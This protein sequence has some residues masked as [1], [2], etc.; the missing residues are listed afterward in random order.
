MSNIRSYFLYTAA[1]FILMFSLSFIKPQNSQAQMSQNAYLQK[2][3]AIMTE[4]SQV[5]DKVSKTAIGLQ[6]A[7]QDKCVNEFGFYQEIVGSLISRLSSTAPPTKMKPLHIKS[8]EALNDYSTGLNL[9]ASACVDE[10]YAM[11][12]KLVNSA[13]GY[14]TKADQQVAEVNTLIASPSLI[15]EYATTVDYIAE[16]CGARWANNTDMQNYCIRTQTEARA[17]LANMLQMNPKGTPGSAVIGDCTKTWTD[18]S[19]SYNYRMI[20]FCAQN[21]IPQ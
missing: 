17:E 9:Y 15:P 1:I 18:P 13:T 16:W 7:P 12:G 14:I 3:Y 4:L 10:D 21:K 5:G 2:L 11:K 19:G 8:M 20:V 6:S